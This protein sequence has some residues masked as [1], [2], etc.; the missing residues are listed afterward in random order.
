MT[1]SHGQ[2]PPGT[3]AILGSGETTAVGRRVLSAI[4]RQ[5]DEPRTIAVLDTPAGF[6]PNYTSL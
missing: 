3:V 1:P 2:A 4:L 6:Q 5:L